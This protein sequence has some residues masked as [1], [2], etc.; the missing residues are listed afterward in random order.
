M[1]IITSS[2]GLAFVLKLLSSLAC[3]VHVHIFL[4]WMQI[5]LPVGKVEGCPIAIGI[6]GPRGSDEGLLEV[7]EKLY[8]LLQ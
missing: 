2:L 7:A 4:F 8:P 1:D 3:T 5:T 6:I